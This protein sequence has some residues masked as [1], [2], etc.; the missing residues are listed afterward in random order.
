[1]VR[2]PFFPSRP[3]FKV[4]VVPRPE[5]SSADSPT[6][7]FF[8]STPSP[9]KSP[10]PWIPLELQQRIRRLLLPMFDLCIQAKEEPCSPD[11]VK[12][13]ENAGSIFK[14]DH[15]ACDE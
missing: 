9:C 13:E 4:R 11:P 6:N 14:F 15:D 8:K 10:G 3:D 2:F 7:K 1:M 12:Q 5:C